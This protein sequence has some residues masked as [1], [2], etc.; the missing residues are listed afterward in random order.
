MGTLSTEF[1]NDSNLKLTTSEVNNNKAV[2]KKA[3]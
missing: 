2:N 3:L 1:E